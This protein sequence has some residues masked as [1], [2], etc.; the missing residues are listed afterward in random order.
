MRD[1]LVG[2]A[3]TAAERG[4]APEALVRR[5]IRRLCRQR[6]DQVRSEG[7]GNGVDAMVRRLSRGPI[8]PH[9]GEAKAQHYEVPAEVFV[10]TLGPRLKYSCGYWPDSVRT[11]AEAEDAALRETC[12]RAGVSDGMNI[13]DLGCGWGA[14]SLWMAEAYPGARITAMSNSDG[15]RSFIEARAR[16]RG[17][18]N[19]GVIT[20]DMNDFETADRFDRILSVEMFE[21]MRNY[22]R[23]LKAVAGWLADGGRLFV[24][25]FAHRRHSYTFETEGAANWMAR[26]FFTG[27]LMPSRDLL[28]RF[29]DD[30]TLVDQWWWDGTHYRRTAEAWLENMASN[31]EALIETFARSCT[32][33]EAGRRFRRRRLF[34]MACSEMWGYDGGAEWGVAQYLFEP[35]RLDRRRTVGG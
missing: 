20:A 31:R 11:L 32:P 26:N 21:H 9:A 28:P 4:W 5:G 18:D 1:L 29:Q 15:Q 33:G 8:A 10:H 24:H 12:R 13:L 3:L 35:S 7:P 34:Y 16:R 6:L 2:A 19:V 25:V 22:R 30:V 27:G 23:L 14:L 17:L